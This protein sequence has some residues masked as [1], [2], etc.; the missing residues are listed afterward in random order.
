MFCP[1]CGTQNPEDG[2]FCRKCGTDLV[3]VSEALLG[4][5]S[6]YA[7][8]KKKKKKKPSWDSAFGSISI[9]VAFLF[10]AGILGYT[11]A[12]GGHVWWYW[13]LI[14]GFSMIGSGLAT[15]MRIRS[16]EQPAAPS[17]SVPVQGQFEGRETQALPPNRTSYVS[18]DTDP[19]Y[20]TGDLVPSS[21]VE[22]TTKLLERDDDGNAVGS[23]RK[24]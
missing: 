15:V 3:G 14:P 17:A 16:M 24:D 21:V 18:P 8:S 2:K 11:G 6:N 12:A 9:G 10:I 23:S 7:G 20:E 22:N 19:G 13:M 4:G 1:K 5:S